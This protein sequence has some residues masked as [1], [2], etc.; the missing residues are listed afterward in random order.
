MIWGKYASIWYA[1]I[2]IR[3]TYI[4]RQMGEIETTFSFLLNEVSVDRGVVCAK[5]MEVIEV[6]SYGRYTISYVGKSRLWN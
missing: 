3:N 4:D 5:N 6:G 2:T 1:F